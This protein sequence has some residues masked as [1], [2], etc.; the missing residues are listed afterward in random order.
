MAPI[1]KEVQ[2]VQCDFQW[3]IMSPCESSDYFEVI[4]IFHETT[5][6]K[7]FQ[8]W[9]KFDGKMWLHF[10]GHCPLGRQ[11]EETF[12]NAQW[13]QV[14]TVQPV[15][16]SNMGESWICDQCDFAFSE[17]GNLRRYLKTHSSKISNKCDQCEFA[18]IQ[19]CTLFTFVLSALSENLLRWHWSS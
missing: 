7:H 15:W 18:S 6:S 10:H 16:L 19:A 14:K 4:K 9:G 12:E 3:C 1:C 11:F 13:R 8:K 2:P 17:A 5:M